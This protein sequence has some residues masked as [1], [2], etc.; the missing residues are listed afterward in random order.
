MV[1]G[2]FSVR[3][4]HSSGIG[5][6]KIVSTSPAKGCNHGGGQPENAAREFV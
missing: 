6:N 1:I 2:T 5:T 4:L 3:E